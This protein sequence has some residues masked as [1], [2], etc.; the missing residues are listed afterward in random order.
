MK[1]HQST[2]MLTFVLIVFIAVSAHAQKGR[3]FVVPTVVTAHYTHSEPESHGVVSV[4]FGEQKVVVA[5]QDLARK[6]EY[7]VLLLDESIGQ[8]EKIGIL[9]TDRKGSA[10][11]EYLTKDLLETHNAL[12]I[13]KGED[14]IQ[15]AQLQE[16]SLGCIC[17]HSGGSIVTQRLDQLCYECPCGVNYEICC[18]GK[19]K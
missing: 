15:Y 1:S 4:R 7:D 10:V 12:L 2:P 11:M 9:N 13:V 14:V 19:K 8:R 6:A 5:V 18:G 17:R 3:T 16:S